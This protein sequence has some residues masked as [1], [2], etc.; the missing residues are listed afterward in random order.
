MNSNLSKS[1]GADILR[2]IAIAMVVIYHA[3]GPVH[4]YYLPWI[5]NFRDFK[6]PP[7]N[8]FYWLYPVTFGWTGVALFFVIS[9]FCI[10]LSFLRARHFEISNF[11]LA[12]ILAYLPRVF[13]GLAGFCRHRKNPP[14]IEF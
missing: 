1:H 12:A 8:S 6:S 5:G 13:G 3:C 7:S 10:H 4:G 14:N 11:F 9:G 2:G